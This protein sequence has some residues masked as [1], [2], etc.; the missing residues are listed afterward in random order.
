MK[1]SNSCGDG[2]RHQPQEDLYHPFKLPV[3]PDKFWFVTVSPPLSFSG[4]CLLFGKLTF[5]GLF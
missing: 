2:S 4:T 5:P 1:Q 3:V